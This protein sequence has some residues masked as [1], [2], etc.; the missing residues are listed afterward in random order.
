[1][2]ILRK[3]FACKKMSTPETLSCPPPKPTNLWERETN[4]GQQQ[5]NISAYH[6]KQDLLDA[7]NQI[8]KNTM[9]TLDRMVSLWQ[10]VCYIDAVKLPGALVECGVWKGGAVGLMALAHMRKGQIPT[11]HLH[12]F[13]SFEGLPEPE[14]EHDGDLIDAYANGRTGGQLQS[15]GKCVGTLPEVEELF[16]TIRYPESLLHMHKGWFQTTVPQIAPT[17]GPIAVL[18]LDGDWYAS[19]KVCL[20]HL[21]D[22]VVPGGFI[23]LDDYGRWIGSKKATDEF[24]QQRGFKPFMIR[25]DA[26]CYY[27]IKK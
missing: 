22:N 13:D 17:M 7:L 24:A 5:I 9:T 8:G 11:R 2:E 25:V 18:R 23:I 1:M 20:E 4:F 19:T 15:I 14:A 3:L 16:T 27:F 26:A 21:F 10:Q 6:G 12:L